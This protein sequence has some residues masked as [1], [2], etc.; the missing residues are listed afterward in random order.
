LPLKIAFYAPLHPPAGDAAADERDPSRYLMEALARAGHS[1]DLAS[2]FRSYDDE[3]D[4]DRQLARRDEGTALARMLAEQWRSGQRGRRPDLWLT[5]HVYYKAPDWLGPRATAELGIPYVIAEAS[6]APK[7][8]GGR[9]AVGHDATAEAIRRADIVFCP[10]RHDMIGVEPLVL[11]RE[12]VV[13]LHPFLDPAP[14]SRA[15]GLREEYRGAIAGTC[16]L[17]PGAPWILAVSRMRNP[18]KVASFK[19]LVAALAKLRDTGWRLLVAGDGPART[20]IETAVE[21]ALPGRASF[22]G[23]LEFAELAPVYAAC[24]L[25][26]WPAINET[27]GRTAYEAQA[28]G[29]PVVSCALRGVPD[30]VADG[31]TG[32]HVAPG[33]TEALAQAVRALLLNPARRQALGGAASAFIAAERSIEAAALRLGRALA[34]FPGGAP[35]SKQPSG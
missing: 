20:E 12:R 19:A 11:R 27:Y 5:H 9:W 3:G 16:G 33:D 18:D 22:L 28:A 24:D 23:E 8:A 13:R 15:T 14:Y 31:Q 35:A 7:Q 10:T 30:S 2:D 4:V 26:V 6:F 32:L 29:I 25:L 34:R 21:A 17:D 1:V